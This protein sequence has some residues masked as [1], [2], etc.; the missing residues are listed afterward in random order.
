MD[1][2]RP[3]LANARRR[4]RLIIAAVVTVLVAV[5]TFGVTRLKPAAPEVEA[6][7]LFIDTV[8][9]GS[10]VRQVRGSGVLVPEQVRWIPA[11][12]EARVERILVR[13]GTVVQADTVM[14]ELSNPEV[15]Q[16]ARDA[17]L[18]LG[19]A[20]A[21]LRRREIELQS[22][23]L[24]QQALAADIE[25]QRSDAESQAAV[26]DELARNGL[27]SELTRKRSRNRADQLQ[28]RSTIEKQRLDI[29]RK[30]AEADMLMQRSR[31]DQLRA[32][33]DLR[34]QQKNAMQVRAGIDGVLQQLP[35]EVGQRV[36]AGTN[37]ARVAQPMPLKAELRIS[38]T[39]A[40]DVAAGQP[41]TIDTRNGT[42][43]GRVTRVDPAVQN[44]TIGVDVGFDGPLPRGARPDLTVDGVIELERLE[45][46]LYT[47]RPVQGSDGATI[48]LFK[49]VGDEA[50]QTSVSIGRTSVSSVEIR[51]GLKEGDRV[52]LSDMSA[53]SE[54]PRIRLK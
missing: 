19:S 51:S 4:K 39:Q 9:R 20:V 33:H 17:E 7:G 21:E 46:V 29:A 28:N 52:I 37:L 23:I 49:V 40:R 53:W 32:L 47:G 41:V 38:E 22:A 42:V 35:I 34:R 12:T 45:N 15:E 50:V 27:T 25:A 2:H 10:F 13:P 5:A 30:A 3:D 31:V 8:R 26:D 16:A 43:V 36:A 6:G 48:G 24:S 1:V 54:H 18:Q 44:G 11:A 14:L